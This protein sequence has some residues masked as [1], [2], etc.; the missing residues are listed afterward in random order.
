M[1]ENKL[2]WTAMAETDTIDS[3]ISTSGEEWEG[4][5]L[6][7]EGKIVKRISKEE[8]QGWNQG[9]LQRPFQKIETHSR[10]GRRATVH[11]K[12]PQV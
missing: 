4:L 9:Q 1:M 8:I 2:N 5:P 7:Y 12:Q 11:V 6:F 10:R 3:L